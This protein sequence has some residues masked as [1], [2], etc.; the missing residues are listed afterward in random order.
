[1][2]RSP[3]GPCALQSGRFTRSA[4][5]VCVCVCV[6]LC[7]CVCVC[8]DALVLSRGGPASD[9]VPSLVAR[10]QKIDWARRALEVT[11]DAEEAK[12]AAAA[13]AE[14]ARALEQLANLW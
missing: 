2:A 8:A 11:A 6:C 12:A 9:W 4:V 7:V 10:A 5:C 3:H 13:I 14:C 1:M